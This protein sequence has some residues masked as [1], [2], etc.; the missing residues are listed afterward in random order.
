MKVLNNSLN[1]ESICPHCDTPSHRLHQNHRYL[2]KDLPFS[3][4]PVYLEIILIAPQV[5]ENDIHS[6]AKRSHVTTEEIEIMLKDKE[7]ECLKSKN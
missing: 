1:K 7:Q 4:Q 6:I 3:G 2:V 5:L